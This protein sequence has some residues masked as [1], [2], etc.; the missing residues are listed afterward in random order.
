MKVLVGYSTAHGST[1]EIAERVAERLERHGLD[2]DV[3]DLAHVAEPGRYDAYVIGSAVHGQ[4]WLPEARAFVA[5]HAPELAAR[6]V[7]LFSVGMPGALRPPLRLLAGLQPTVLV[8]EFADRVSFRDHLVVSGVVRDEHLP[9]LGRL[10][11]RLVTH[12][13]G[14]YR[15]WARIDGWADGVARVL[16]GL[17]TPTAA[18]RPA[19]DGPTT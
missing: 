12:G 1:R 7:W 11:M 19:P 2:P 10:A 3:V 15:D 14:D 5:E 16:A 13:P 18:R 8:A 4:R 6:P 17:P 9:L